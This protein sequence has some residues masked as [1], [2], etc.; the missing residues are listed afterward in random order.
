MPRCTQRLRYWQT[1]PTY[2]TAIYDNNA[3]G[4][5]ALAQAIE[6]LLHSRDHLAPAPIAAAKQD[7]A[8]PGRP[9]KGKQPR[10]IEIGGDHRSS[11]LPCACQDVRLGGVIQT[12][13]G[14]VNRAVSS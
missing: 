13:A 12:Q 14:D 8:R 5:V 3:P 6:N 1:P 4:Y 10:I 7:Q 11:I 9:G 2:S